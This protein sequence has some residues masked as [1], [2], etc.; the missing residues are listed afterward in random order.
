MSTEE[1]QALANEKRA[2]AKRAAHKLFRI[3]EG[4]GSDLVEHF[5]DDIIAAAVLEISAAARNAVE[6]PPPSIDP[7]IFNDGRGKIDAR[8]YPDPIDTP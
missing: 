2:A 4:Y 5:V 1:I 7:H 6:N 3:P 8:V